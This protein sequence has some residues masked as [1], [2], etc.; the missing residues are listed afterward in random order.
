MEDFELP[1][2]YFSLFFDEGQAGDLA[3]TFFFLT[4]LFVAP[5]TA[6]ELTYD[7]EGIDNSFFIKSAFAIS[8]FLNDYN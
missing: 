5:F 4:G 3:C 1:F 2:D 7:I 8:C 6:L